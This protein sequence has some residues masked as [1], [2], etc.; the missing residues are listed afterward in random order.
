MEL[1]RIGLIPITWQDIADVLLLAIGLYF[2]LR[3]FYRSN[4]LG[5]AVLLIFLIVLLKAASLLGLIA[6]SFFLR[7]ILFW[8]GVFLAVILAPELRRWLYGLR[9]LGWLRLFRKEIITEEE[10]E[11]LAEEL[12][13]AV[14]LLSKNGLGALIVLEG[15]DDLGTYIQTGDAVQMPVDARMFLTIF[16]KKSP[17]HD[18]AVIIRGNKIV[19]ARCTLPL[20]E[21]LDLPQNYGQRH[22]AGLGISEQSDAATIVVSEETGLISL[23]YRGE[24]NRLPLPELKKRIIQFYLS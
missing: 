4:L 9:P 17:L 3:W 15:T 5:V 8:V 6:V 23:A 22:R 12:I 19:A 14:Q 7:N 18:G 2:V 10:A 1:F 20:S 24:M 11:K 16:E 13:E 21:R